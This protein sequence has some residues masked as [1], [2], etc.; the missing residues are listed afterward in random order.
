[1]VKFAKSWIW[2]VVLLASLKRSYS[3]DYCDHKLCPSGKAHIGC[4]N[5]GKLGPKCPKGAKPIEMTAQLKQLILDTHNK[6]RSTLATGGVEWL[7]KAAV[8][9]TLTW[10]DELAETAQMNSN[11][12]I[13]GHDACHNTDLF[14]NSGQNINYF[15]TSA[16]TIDVN[17]QVPNL[18]T[19]W[20]DERHDVNQNMVNTMYDPGKS[21]M[22]FHF[23]VLGSDKV[24]KLG[25]GITQWKP[26]KGW[27]QIYLVCNYSFNDFVGI[28]IYVAGEPCS[29]CTKGCN[30]KYKGLCAEDEP[31]AQVIDYPV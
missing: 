26:D 11:R 7:P 3:T 18:I 2:L 19:S 8:M 6:Y 4:K 5:D 1:M 31:V 22:V 9:P 12:C 28:P 24:N 25:C 21:I 27:I 17:A 10:D 23:A 29:Q 16:D 30:T 14:K 13:R 15:A 20:W